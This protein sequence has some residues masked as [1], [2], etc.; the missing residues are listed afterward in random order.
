[1]SLLLIVFYW[2]GIPLGVFQLA[3]WLIRRAQSTV[4]KG[5][6]VVG[7]IGFFTWFLWVA[8]G[9]NMWLDHQIREMCAK[10]GGVKV[11]ETVTLPAERFDKYDQIR[12]P[13]KRYSKPG[14]EYFYEDDTLYLL[15]GN[16]EIWRSIFRIIRRND[17][18]VMGEAVSYHRRGGG[19]FGPWH[20]SSFGCPKN[21]GDTDLEKQIIIKAK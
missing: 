10:D 5:L 12:V 21:A 1:M 13:H 15:K 2:I 4:I 8:V 11:Y 3:R 16:P 6:V 18:K 7:T 17:E 20:D 14:D 19:L 9:R